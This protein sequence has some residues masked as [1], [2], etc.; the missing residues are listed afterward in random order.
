VNGLLTLNRS[1][2]LCKASRRSKSG[3]FE[4]YWPATLRPDRF[5]FQLSGPMYK[6]AGLLVTGFLCAN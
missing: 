2:R 4:S 1:T 5:E 6:K 3:A